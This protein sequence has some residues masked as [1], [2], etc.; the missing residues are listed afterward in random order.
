MLCPLCSKVESKAATSAEL[1]RR[2]TIGEEIT[3]WFMPPVNHLHAPAKRMDL[4]G[5]I[6]SIGTAWVET[7][8]SDV[9][10]WI[11][12]QFGKRICTLIETIL[13]VGIPTSGQTRLDLLDRLLGHMV[14]LGIPE[15]RRAEDV[16]RTA[17]N[18]G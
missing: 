8:D 14:R 15:A 18:Q 17:N 6:L 9:R 5:A 10:F 16:L 3:D 1:R 7:Y 13:K 2:R 11:E 4:P 12:Y